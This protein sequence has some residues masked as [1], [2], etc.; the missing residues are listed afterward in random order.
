MTHRKYIHNANKILV[1]T[2]AQ[3]DQ[4]STHEVPVCVGTQVHMPHASWRCA[5]RR[6]VQHQQINAMLNLKQR[7]ERHSGTN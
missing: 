5:R 4:L 7:I 2:A 6:L 3:I 1:S